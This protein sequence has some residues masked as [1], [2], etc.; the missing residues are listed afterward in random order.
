[1]E[2]AITMTDRLKAD[3][4][5]ML[6]EHEAIVAALKDL[7]DVAQKENKIEYVHFADKLMLHAQNEE[8]GIV[9]RT[10]KELRQ[11]ASTIPLGG[12]TYGKKRKQTLSY[13]WEKT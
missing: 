5:D 3:L 7:I 9:E 6:K 12:N 11:T 13:N 2:G 1:M 10:Q 4:P 8:E